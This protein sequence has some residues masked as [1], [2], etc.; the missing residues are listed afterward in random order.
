MAPRETKLN[1][2]VELSPEDRKLLKSIAKAL[3]VTD[4]ESFADTTAA[5][6]YG[7]GNSG[8]N[9]AKDTVKR[10]IEQPPAEGDWLLTND[11]HEGEDLE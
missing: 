10:L 4:D 6:V 2:V 5:L 9:T 7:Q 1:V 11:E 3:G 8:M